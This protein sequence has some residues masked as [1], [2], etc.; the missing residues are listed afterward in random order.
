MSGDTGHGPFALLWGKILN[1]SIW[2]RGSKETRL[3][4]ITLLAMKNSEG[5]I[6]SSLVGLADRAKIKP[7][8][9]KLSLKV[10]LSPDPDDTSG[11]DEGRR[12]RE[13]PGG[14]EIINHDLYRFSSEAK[15]EMWRQQKAEQRA[16]QGKPPRKKNRGKPLPMENAAVRAFENGD[17]ARA[18]EIAGRQVEKPIVQPME[19][20][21]SITNREASMTGIGL[22]ESDDEDFSGLAGT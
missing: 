7:E 11:V 5:R 19:P 18:E 14:W 22:P 17:L 2:I 1:S 21:Q 3:L 4:W 10:L 13:I 15:R 6:F 20:L 8:E 12:I 16:K 9:C